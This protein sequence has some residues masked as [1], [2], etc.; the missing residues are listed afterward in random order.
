MSEEYLGRILI[1][2]EQEFK[3]ERW[4]VFKE[5]NGEVFYNMKHWPRLIRRLFWKKPPSDEETFKLLLFLWGNGCPMDVAL[6]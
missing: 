3:R 2:K 6:K 4:N 5:I 1:L